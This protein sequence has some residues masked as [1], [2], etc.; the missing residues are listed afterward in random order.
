MIINKQKVINDKDF[1][2]YNIS[3]IELTP[4]EILDISAYANTYASTPIFPQ[5]YRIY[6]IDP[7]LNSS[8]KIEYDNI[9]YAYDI[10]KEGDF[11][12]FNNFTEKVLYIEN[13]PHAEQYKLKLQDENPNI[14][15]ILNSSNIGIC[16][17]DNIQKEILADIYPLEIKETHFNDSSL[18]LYDRN[19]S[20]II[21]QDNS[22]KDNSN[23]ADNSNTETTDI[24]IGYL[25][26]KCIDS[27]KL[28]TSSYYINGINI[29]VYA[30]D[31][32]S[33]NP[34]DI[35]V[36]FDNK[37]TYIKDDKQHFINSQVVKVCFSTEQQTHNKYTRNIIDN[38]TTYRI[39]NVENIAENQVQYTLNGIIDLYKLNNKIYHNKAEL[40][41]SNNNK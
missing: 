1:Y 36:D 2:E 12:I 25:V 13:T 20:Y 26:K 19:N 6:D 7:V 22:K 4:K 32:I 5:S 8:N 27:C 31:E 16:V 37:L 41:Y 15:S 34:E 40:K 24:S 38:E 17:Y 35:S 11:I 39:I 9:S 33:L 30:A 18:Y 10:P 3:G 29:Y 28:D 23:T 14:E 21:I